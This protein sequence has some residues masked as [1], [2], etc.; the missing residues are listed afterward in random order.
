MTNLRFIQRAFTLLQDRPDNLLKQKAREELK[1]WRHEFNERFCEWYRGDCSLYNVAPPLD[2]QKVTGYSLRVNAAM[3]WL[4]MFQKRKYLTDLRLQPK[5]FV[6]LRLL[7]IGCGPFPNILA[8]H[9]CERHGLD[10]LVEKYRQLGF[11]ILEW[12]RAGYEYHNAS[13]EQM[14]F[15]NSSFD[16]VISV[17]AIDH[18][19]DFSNTALEIK[20]ILRPNGLFCM[21]VHYHKAFVPEPIE[22]NDQVFL[23]NYGWVSNLHKVFEGNTKDCDLYTAPAGESFVLWSNMREHNV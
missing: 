20:R 21:H 3:T 6:G 22:L 7:D 19:D 9:N 17:N 5:S 10:P 14:P 12:S 4:E 15:A 8:F 1:F 2:N 11:P 16:A 23:K 18:V 13:A